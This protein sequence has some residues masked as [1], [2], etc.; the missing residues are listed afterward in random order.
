MK[1]RI[2]LAD[3]H[4]LV[5]D[6]LRRILEA[7][8]DL[9]AA[10]QDGR[11]LFAAVEQFQP[12]LAVCDISMPQLTGLDAFQNCLAAHFPTRFVFV[13]A[14][15]DV[16]LATRAIRLGAFGYVLKHAA[17]EEL[18]AALREALA[19]RTFI[20]PRIA[21]EVHQRLSRNP[22]ANNELTSRERE[23]LQLLA[24]GKTMKEIAA[25]LCVSPRTVEFH[26][27]NITDKTGLHSSAELA[28]YAIRQGISLEFI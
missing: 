21:A 28:R 5:L 26:K 27:N 11:A 18:L 10:V 19:G 4:A 23:V 15:P 8:F 3:D 9:V 2:I 13:T 14:S 6:G 1:H 25:I 20:S 16:A 24:E 12:E 17:T 7:E 22:A